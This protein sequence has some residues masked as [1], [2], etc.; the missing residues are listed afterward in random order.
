MAAARNNDREAEGTAAG[1]RNVHLEVSS[2][3]QQ[4]E[5]ARPDQHNYARSAACKRQKD[6]RGPAN[7]GCHGGAAKKR[8]RPRRS[9]TIKA[10]LINC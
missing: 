6:N 2:E 5:A 3:E 4:Y 1:P 9:G 8:K 7:E 10:T